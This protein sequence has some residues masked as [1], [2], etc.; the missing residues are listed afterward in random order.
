MTIQMQICSTIPLPLSSPVCTAASVRYIL[1]TCPW[2][3]R[4]S[5]C[6]PRPWWPHFCPGPGS[7]QVRLILNTEWQM[8]MVLF[9]IQILIQIII[10]PFSDG[11]GCIALVSY[12]AGSCTTHQTTRTSSMSSTMVP[13]STISVLRSMLRLRLAAPAPPLLLSTSAVSSG[14]GLV[15]WHLGEILEVDTTLSALWNS[16]LHLHVPEDCVNIFTQTH[17]LL[18]IR[19]AHWHHLDPDLVKP[20]A[21]I[22]NSS[23]DCPETAAL[24]AR[25]LYNPLVLSS[26]MQIFEADPLWRIWKIFHL[27]YLVTDV[28]AK[29]WL[30]FWW[31]CQNLMQLPPL[32]DWWNEIIV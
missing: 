18:P 31:L 10:F 25:S 29:L 1:T 9:Q 14:A 11:M 30:I 7:P 13:E 4:C 22:M 19:L 3:G 24:W 2:C 26:E 23:G 17:D 6:G 28:V 12:P 16:S 20:S 21:H 27:K 8:Q 15:R 32:I 5:W